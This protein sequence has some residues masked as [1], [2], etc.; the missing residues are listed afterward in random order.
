MKTSSEIFL[1]TWIIFAIVSYLVFY[2]NKNAAFKRKIWPWTIAFVGLVFLGFVTAIGGF[3]FDKPGFYVIVLADIFIS[4]INI[5]TV[6]FCDSCGRTIQSSN[7]FLG[8]S[9]FCPKCGA[10]LD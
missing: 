3:K 7:P 1:V 9:K 10:K 6:R 2:Q 5:K 4:Y 8:P